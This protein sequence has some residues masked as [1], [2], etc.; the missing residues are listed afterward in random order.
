MRTA[1]GPARPSGGVRARGHGR[2]RRIPARKR[3]VEALRLRRRRRCGH[4]RRTE[5]HCYAVGRIRDLPDAERAACG[6]QKDRD[7]H[8]D[9]GD[10]RRTGK[11][12][13][14]RNVP[15]RAIE[16]N[17][18]RKGDGYEPVFINRSNRFTER[19]IDRSAAD[20]KPARKRNARCSRRCVSRLYFLRRTSCAAPHPQNTSG[21]ADRQRQTRGL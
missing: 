18:D 9:R 8:A 11:P 7:A 2:H 1:Q 15:R 19:S 17:A 16:A 4:T 14:R 13:A 6:Q 3:G 5:I 12:A 10:P 21:S 20:G